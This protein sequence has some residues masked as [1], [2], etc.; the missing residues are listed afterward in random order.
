MNVDLSWRERKRKK[1]RRKRFEREELQ[2]SLSLYLSCVFF[3]SLLSV[4]PFSPWLSLFLF[5]FGKA[6]YL[7]SSGCRRGQ[8]FLRV[9]VSSSL[10]FFCL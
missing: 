5:L 6:F 8:V 9:L 3:F 10:V 7:S 4:V 2:Q 1:T